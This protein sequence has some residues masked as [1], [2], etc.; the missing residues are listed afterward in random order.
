M[1]MPVNA[2]FRQHETTYA[3]RNP[4]YRGGMDA[5]ETAVRK[6]DGLHATFPVLPQDAAWREG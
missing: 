2:Y 1:I 3:R 6:N 4:K 5:I